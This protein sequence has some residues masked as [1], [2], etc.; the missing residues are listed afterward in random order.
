MAVLFQVAILYTDLT[1]EDKTHFAELKIISLMGLWSALSNSL[2]CTPKQHSIHKVEQDKNIASFKQCAY[3]NT[4]MLRAL[5]CVI[6][7]THT[8][9]VLK[10]Q[11]R[12]VAP[13]SIKNIDFGTFKYMRLENNK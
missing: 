13:K 3:L 11:V 9:Q 4:K 7:G 12:Q 10:Y 2:Y 8:F 6:I 5:S 1:I